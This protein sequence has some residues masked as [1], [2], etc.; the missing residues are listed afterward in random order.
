MCV[1]SLQVAFLKIEV[2]LIYNVVL[3]PSVK[4][5]W[6]SY[7]YTYTF[8]FRFFSII[9]YYT[10]Y[11]SLCYTVGPC[12]AICFLLN[13]TFVTLIHINACAYRAFIFIAIWYSIIHVTGGG[14]LF[15]A[16]SNLTKEVAMNNISKSSGTHS[17][18]TVSL[19]YIRRS[20]TTE[21]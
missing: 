5:K 20:R 13:I 12:F 3:V 17:G 2:L 14:Q 10:E 1:Y 11:S 19:C 7:T 6:F 21:S 9:G 4:A 18:A 16:F 15:L 8:F